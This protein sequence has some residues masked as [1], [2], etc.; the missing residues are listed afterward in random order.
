MADKLLTITEAAKYLDIHPM[1][2]YKWVKKRKIP[3]F[4]VGKIWR[5]RKDKIDAWLER[6]EV[7]KSKK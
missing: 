1:T 4:K 2:L 7:G 5:F 3:V 6:Q